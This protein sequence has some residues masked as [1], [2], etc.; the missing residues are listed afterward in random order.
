MALSFIKYM[1]FLN[2][3][4]LEIFDPCIFIIFSWIPVVEL[5]ISNRPLFKDTNI[6]SLPCI[7]PIGF[8]F[9]LFLKFVK[10][11]VILRILPVR[12]SITN[13]YPSLET[14]KIKLSI[15]LGLKLELIDCVHLII[16]D[17]ASIE[18]NSFLLFEN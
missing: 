6:L 1:E 5:T 7:N 17:L 12:S 9:F 14:V 18:K 16:P 10:I 4:G 13:R 2:I 3:K 11:S 8:K 15:I